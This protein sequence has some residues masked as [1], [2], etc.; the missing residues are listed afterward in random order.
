MGSKSEEWC[1]FLAMELGL[2]V[3]QS[4][5]TLEQLWNDVLEKLNGSLSVSR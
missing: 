1:V 2:V 5:V 3:L 4:L